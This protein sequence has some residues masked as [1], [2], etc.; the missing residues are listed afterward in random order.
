MVRAWFLACFGASIVLSQ[1]CSSSDTAPPAPACNTLVNDGPT[2]SLTVVLTA[3]PPANGGT[4]VDGT[5]VLSKATLYTNGV[6]VTPPPNAFSAVLQMAGHTMQQVGSI[7]G[8]ESRYTSTFTVSGSNVT[9]EDTC[10]AP[11]STT[12]QFTAT[13][14][15]L[16]ISGASTVGTVEQTYMKR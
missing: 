5:Y 9:T 16:T 6:T 11:K 12:Y 7:N 2:V 4:V 10:P 8:A 13:A 1:A 14:T 15:L 3:A